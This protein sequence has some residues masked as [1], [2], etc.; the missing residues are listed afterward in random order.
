MSIEP[1]SRAVVFVAM[2][3]AGDRWIASLTFTVAPRGPAD[4]HERMDR[5]HRRYPRPHQSRPRDDQGRPLA[6]VISNERSRTSLEGWTFDPDLI[7]PG[8]SSFP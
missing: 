6:G 5:H 1:G 7:K 3:H 4:H 8:I 2:R